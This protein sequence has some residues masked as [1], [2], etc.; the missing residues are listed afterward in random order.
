MKTIQREEYDTIFILNR[1]CNPRRS[2]SGLFFRREVENL[3][4][5][6]GSKRS[7]GLFEK[8]MR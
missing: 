6:E 8:G 2:E 7:L 5:M 4:P 1:V 3:Q